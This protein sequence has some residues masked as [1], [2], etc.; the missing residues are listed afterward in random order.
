MRAFDRLAVVLTEERFATL[1]A[2][3]VRPGDGREHGAFLYGKVHEG[4]QVEVVDTEL[5]EPVDFTTQ[6]AG[7]L[8]L[9][10]DMLQ[11][12]I[13]RAHE[14]ETAL[15]EAHSHPFSKGPHV[16]FSPIDVGGLREI[17]PHVVWRLPKRP[18]VAL[19]FGQHAFD[20]LFWLATATEEAPS[21]SVDLVIDGTRLRGSGESLLRWG[22]D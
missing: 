9:R 18:Y 2:S 21:G 8:E 5:L 7:Y 4:G 19:V 3:L 15:I 6:S 11:N 17:A 22:M 12:V 14:S 10:E 13:R 16:G 1:H 20:G